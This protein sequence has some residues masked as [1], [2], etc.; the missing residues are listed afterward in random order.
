MNA[1][2]KQVQNGFKKWKARVG[3]PRAKIRGFFVRELYPFYQEKQMQRWETEGKSEGGDYAFPA[4]SPYWAKKKREL[5]QKYGDKFPGGD[6]RLTFTGNLA[7]SVIGN[8]PSAQFG[9][10][11][12]T[13]HRRSITD[14]KLTVATTIPYGAKVVEYMRGKG[15][16]SFMDFGDKTRNEMR[17]KIANFLRKE[18]A[19]G[20]A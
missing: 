14:R 19:S 10:L 11:G 5:K 4:S 6:K 12:R 8:L 1:K 9:V 2:F 20:R 3:E 15:R 17:N 13:Y 18:F 16:K 7:S